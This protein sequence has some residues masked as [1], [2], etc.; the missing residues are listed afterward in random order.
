VL[1]AADAVEYP[2][3]SSTVCV[4]HEGDKPKI[5][6]SLE[7]AERERIRFSSNLLKLTTIVR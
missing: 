7:N 2:K 5:Y 3:Q 4:T 6:I 1:T